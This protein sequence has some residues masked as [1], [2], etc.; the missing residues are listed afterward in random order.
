MQEFFGV[1]NAS[2]G[3]VLGELVINLLLE[4]VEAYHLIRGVIQSISLC[5]AWLL[6]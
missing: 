4:T 6:N 3:S 5:L 1:C 2:F